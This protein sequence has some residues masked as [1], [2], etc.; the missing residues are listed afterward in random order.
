MSDENKFNIESEG[1]KYRRYADLSI[2]NKKINNSEILE[3]KTILKSRPSMLGIIVNDWCNLNCI[4]C[5]EARRKNQCTLSAS[6][7]WKIEE[8][9]PYLEKIDW[10]GGEFFRLDYIRD[11]FLFMKHYPRIRHTITT[12]GILLNKEWVELLLNLNTALTFSIDSP[13]RE[14]YEYIRQG[15]NYNELIER[16]N[17]IS[18]LEQK[19]KKRLERYLT[20]VVM[21]S[22]YLHL[23]DFVE[24]AKKYKFSSVFFTPVKNL[25]SEEN[26]F[27]YSNQDIQ[28][29]LN[30][31]SYLL[32]D[33]FAESN[34]ELKWFLPDARQQLDSSQDSLIKNNT[35]LLC[36][37][38]WR[39]MF[40]C[41][42]RNGDILP[43]CWCSQPIGNIFRDTLLEVWN[44]VKMQEY[45]RKITS[46]DIELCSE[47]YT[48][49][50]H[51][52]FL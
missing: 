46:N 20:V 31:V 47:C 25:D 8:L 7:L 1:L 4:M 14:T 15:G 49:G 40:I 5:S 51:I 43:D 10:Q 27:K 21:K 2:N 39:G 9:L 22:N 38:P 13:H 29:Y 30:E 28:K 52:R 36:D 50:Q 48:E 32:R 44:N 35:N 18:N 17:L 33:R 23:V 24:F 16:L 45:R 6:V 42:D 3:R 11:I 34:I 26:I 41:A 37:I 12:N 19:H